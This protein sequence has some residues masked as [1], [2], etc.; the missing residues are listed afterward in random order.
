MRTSIYKTISDPKLFKEQLLL[1]SQQFREIIYLDSNDYPQNYSSYDCVLAVDALT[2]IKT[3]FHNAFED[4]KQ[5]QQS[6]KDW[7]FGYLSYDLKNDIEELQSHNFD[8]LEFPDLYFFQPKKLFLLKGNELEIQYL[9]MC[10]D[11]VEEDFEEISVQYSVFSNKDS[12][13]AIQQRIRKENYLQKVA[14]ILEYIHRGDIY[15][16]NFCMEFFAENAILDPF[17]KFIKLNE[18]SQPPFA[19]FFKNNT[20]FLLS[21]TPERYVR[22]EGELIVSQPIK[23]TS[24]RFLDPIEDEKSKNELAADAKERSENIMITDLVRNDLSRTAQKGSVEVKELCKIYSFMQ[25]HQMISTVISKLDAQY[26][27]LDVLKTTFPMGSMTGAPKISVMK[28]IEELE[29]T[30]RGLYSGAVGYFT[31]NG[32]FDFNVV[33]R[34]IL[35]NQEKKYVSFSVGSAITSQSIPEKEYEECL[36]KAKAMREVLS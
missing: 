7:L 34:S 27:A 35:Y 31:P 20:H 2:S 36:L 14:K 3:D 22:K 1:W 19:V 8:G 9:N 16:A 32:D 10:G 33:I 11:E 28:I 30:K 23:G 25:V 6:T 24:K 21:A 15:E 13:T 29:E 18:I 17:K 26:S 5:Y 12:Q 4:L